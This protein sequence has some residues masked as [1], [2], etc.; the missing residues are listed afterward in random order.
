[1]KHESLGE[2]T[3]H[4]IRG[5]LPHL[6]TKDAYPPLEVSADGLVTI[7]IDA[8]FQVSSVTIQGVQLK[9]EK[10]NLLEQALVK[11]INKAIRHVAKRN[12]ERVVLSVNKSGA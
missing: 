11:A 5:E 9:P 2:S 7:E 8:L 1:M 4:K 3:F 12:A 6:F 10:A